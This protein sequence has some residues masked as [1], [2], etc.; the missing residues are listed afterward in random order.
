M[1]VRIKI[2]GLLDWETIEAMDGLPVHEVGFVFAPSKR[3]VDKLKAA[4]LIKALYKLKSANNERPKA[5][6]VFLNA[7]IEEVGDVLSEAPLDVIQLH[8]D[9][10]PAYCKAIKSKYPNKQVWKVFGIKNDA[11]TDTSISLENDV[12]SKLSGYKD[13]VDAI[14]I[15]APGG[16]SGEPFNWEVIAIYE[17]IAGSYHLPLYVA[18]G[19]HSDNVGE[20][21]NNYSPDGIDVSSG[22]ETNGHK[23][24][25]KIRSFVRRVIER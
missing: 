9:E 21:L 2:C 10:S 11:D 23:D 14:L 19:L 3:Q 13:F 7:S 24:I 18:G 6:G 1:S 22:V 17:R 8:G 12:E 25:E 15:D 16:G 5:V 20:L 4:E